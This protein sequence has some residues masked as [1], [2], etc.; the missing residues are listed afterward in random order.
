MGPERQPPRKRGVRS[1]MWKKLDPADRLN[2][3]DRQFSLRPSTTLRLALAL[4]NP[5]QRPQPSP[6]PLP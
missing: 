3:S 4:R 1:Y 2:G 5:E 6:R